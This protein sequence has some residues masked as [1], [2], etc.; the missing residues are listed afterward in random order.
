MRTIDTLK[1]DAEA[2]DKAAQ[3]SLGYAYRYGLDVE[4][5]HEESM[6]WFKKSAAQGHPHA[7]G[8]VDYARRAEV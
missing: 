4:V 8:F 3:Y 6:I 1:K 5:D 2:G 7:K